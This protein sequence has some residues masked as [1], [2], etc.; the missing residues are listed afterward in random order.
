M[1]KAPYDEKEY[2]DDLGVKELWGEK[3]YTTYER[4]GI[5]PTIGSKWHLGWLYRAKE[6]KQFCLQKHMQRFLQDWFL[7]NHHI[8]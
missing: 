5:R 6:Q 4:T 8:R 7:I 1:N 2:K 3:G